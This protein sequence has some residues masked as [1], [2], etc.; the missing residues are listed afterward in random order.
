MDYQLPR[1]TALA[2]E[3]L[4][5]IYR[6]IE[7]YKEKKWPMVFKVGLTHDPIWRYENSLYGY[8]HDRCMK[9][10]GMRVVFCT[11]SAAAAAFAEAAA[12]QRFKGDPLALVYV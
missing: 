10:D 12:I 1:N 7:K 9:W 6:C 8:Q 4:R 3:V 5:H 2:G 11:S